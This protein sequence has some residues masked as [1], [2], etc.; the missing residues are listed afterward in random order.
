MCN[1]T[2]PCLGRLLE[3]AEA[4]PYPEWLRDCQT[5]FQAVAWIMPTI[6]DATQIRAIVNGVNR[7]SERAVIT[8][9]LDVHSNLVQPPPEGTPRDLGWAAA[10]WVPSIG[11]PDDQTPGN[12]QQG[13]GV[14]QAQARAQRGASSVLRYRLSQGLVFVTNNVPYIQRLNDGH[15]RQSPAGFVQRAIEQAVRATI[16]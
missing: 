7:L 14:S 4:V 6:P 3:L 2:Y 1:S 5:D 8:I 15:S 12:P 13:G 9:T 10:N 16:P 11:R